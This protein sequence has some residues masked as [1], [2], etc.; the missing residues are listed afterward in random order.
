[1][2]LFDFM[3]GGAAAD[4]LVSMLARGVL[5]TLLL[6][7]ARH[8]LR[9]SS[10]AVR[11]AW[12]TT[13]ALAVL[14]LPV[15][16]TLLPGWEIGPYTYPLDALAR[17]LGRDAAAGAPTAGAALLLVWAAGATFL[18]GRLLLHIGRAVAVTDRGDDVA[19]GPLG[20]LARSI[21][22]ELGVSGRVRVILSDAVRVPCTWGVRRPVVLLPAAAAAWPE[23][24]Q[25][26]VLHHELAHVA[27][28]DYLG[29][30]W[31]ELVRALYWP[32]PL[33]WALHRT[34]RREQE[35]ACDDAAVR[36]G[37]P[38]VAYA[39]HLV[40]VGR[41]AVGAAAAPAAALP[42]V[43]ARALRARIASVLEPGTDRRPATMAGLLLTGA[44]IALLSAP[45]AVASPSWICP[46]SP[47]A[48]ASAPE[49]P[50]S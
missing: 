32:N 13:G 24:M 33:A 45:I 23:E 10:S 30:L 17:P 50:R 41:H 7:L 29:L 28:G 19:G 16:T 40:A 26:A 8:A 1:M 15:L 31:L 35:G 22:L 34:G 18:L 5:L 36:A 43:R 47:P 25:R 46:A 48:V 21:G 6:L 44:L 4:L 37:I 11:A 9:R 3:R 38:P 42:M 39:R 14:S 27:R 20:G 12:C 49:L 2:E